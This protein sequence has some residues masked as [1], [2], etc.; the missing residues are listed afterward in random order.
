M[1]AQLETTWEHL[2]TTFPA[3]TSKRMIRPPDDSEFEDDYLPAPSIEKVGEAL[4][5]RHNMPTEISITYV[6]KRK[7]GKSQGK[8]K[9]AFCNKV[10][11]LARYYAAVDFVIWFA[12]DNLREL[13]FSQDQYEALI[14]HE[15]QHA[16]VDPDTLDPIVVGHDFEGFRE[17]V[18]HY[19]LWL[20]DLAAAKESFAQAKM[21]V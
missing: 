1:V 14:H 2:L 7:G 11:G 12:A 15:L 8:E 19:G 4:R 9:L 18:E 5:L 17:N 10:S 21:F 3:T 20:R 13:N 6:W 16:G